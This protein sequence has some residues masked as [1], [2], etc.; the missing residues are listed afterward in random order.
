[1][2]WSDDKNVT[3][4]MAEKETADINFSYNSIFGKK[5]VK[6]EE[7]AAGNCMAYIERYTPIYGTSIYFH[8]EKRHS[9][10]ILG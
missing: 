10:S 2:T 6:P 8:N 9:C 5:D 4:Y 1:M 3:S 7:M